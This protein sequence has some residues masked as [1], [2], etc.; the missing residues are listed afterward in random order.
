MAAHTP[1]AT[2]DT[3][4]VVKGL[5]G[6]VIAHEDTPDRDGNYPGKVILVKRDDCPE[7]R[8]YSTHVIYFDDDHFQVG[9]PLGWEACWGHYDMDEATGRA[10]YAERTQRGF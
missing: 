3:P 10:D 4:S 2:L 8:A 7:S 1:T 5:R 9:D 6:N